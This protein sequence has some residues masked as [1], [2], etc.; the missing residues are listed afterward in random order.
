AKGIKLL[1]MANL[2]HIGYV[3]SMKLF[4]RHSK[5]YNFKQII[6]HKYPFTKAKEALKKSMEEDSPKIVITSH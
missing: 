3:P 1:G 5:Y 4:A 2:A 6:T